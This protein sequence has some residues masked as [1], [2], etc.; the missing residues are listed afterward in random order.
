MTVWAPGLSE[1]ELTERLNAVLGSLHQASG[2][3]SPRVV[4]IG[5]LMTKRATCDFSGRLSSSSA[6]SRFR[7]RPSGC[8]ASCAT[9]EQR[10]RDFS[11]EIALGARR[12]DIWTAIARQSLRPALFGLGIGLV[13]AW[14][15]S[16]LARATCSGGS[17]RRRCRWLAVSVLMVV[18]ASSRSLVPLGVC[19]HRSIRYVAG[20]V[21]SGAR[22]GSRAITTKLMNALGKSLAYMCRHEATLAWRPPAATRQGCL[23]HLSASPS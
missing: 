18:V 6:C 17:H 19:S 21:R 20:G 23:S 3:M 4:S 7:S 8:T 16:G 5:S 13:V 9:S 10:T 14:T 15:L 2:R 12:S 1:T 11:V 22:V